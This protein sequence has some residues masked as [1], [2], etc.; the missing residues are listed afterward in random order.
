MAIGFNG[1]PGNMQAL[2]KQAQKMQEDIAKAQADAENLICFAQ[3]GGGVVKVKMNGKYR[4]VSLEIS[5]EVVQGG[6]NEMLQDLI[7]LAVNECAA[8]VEENVKQQM[9][10]ATGGMSIPGLF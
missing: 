6:D 9:S 2:L 3:A 4:I 1:M 8:Q 10:K 7:T 5:P